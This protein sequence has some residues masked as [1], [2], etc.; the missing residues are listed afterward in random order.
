LAAA[1]AH[2]TNLK[3]LDI[4][5]N[6]I[7]ERGIEALMRTADQSHSLQ[8]L[9]LSGNDITNT[10]LNWIT[11]MYGAPPNRCSLVMHIFVS[12]L[13]ASL[14]SG[15]LDSVRSF[16]MDEVV[17]VGRHPKPRKEVSQP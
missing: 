7:G 1:L 6:N 13:Q 9:E 11:S 17:L 8:S 3:S 14:I 2:A 5:N 15:L 16:Y 12:S 10:G 4:A